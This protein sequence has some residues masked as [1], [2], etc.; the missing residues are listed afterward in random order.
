EKTV[1]NPRTTN[2]LVRKS[3]KKRYRWSVS[4]KYNEQE[5]SKTIPYGIKQSKRNSRK[6]KKRSENRI[7]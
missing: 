3:A 5:G 2:K 1:I 4:D 6:R 7:N